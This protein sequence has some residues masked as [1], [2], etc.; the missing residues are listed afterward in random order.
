MALPRRGTVVPEAALVTFSCL[1]TNDSAFV[2]TKFSVDRHGAGPA[3]SSAVLDAALR[4]RAGGASQCPSQR[5]NLYS[6]SVIY[7]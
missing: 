7:L 2:L 4:T 6:P 1:P 3:F 5:R